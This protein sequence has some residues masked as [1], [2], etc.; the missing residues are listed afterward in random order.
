MRVFPNLAWPLTGVLAIVVAA[1]GM[2]ACRAQANLPLGLPPVPVPDAN[3][4]TPEKVALGEKLFFDRGLSADRTVSCGSCHLPG[5]FFSDSKALSQGIGG[6][7]GLR[8]APSLLN[9]AYARHLMWDG[10]STSL[11]DQMRYP[12]MNPL[13]MGNTPA[14]AVSYLAGN[15][16]YREPFRAAFGDETVVWQRV[17]RAIA[18]YERTLLSGNSDFD[19]YMA[20]DASALSLSAQRGFEIFRGAGGCAGCHVYSTES[21]FFTDFEFHNTG[22]V[23]SEP[24]DLGRYEISKEREDKGA[25]RTPSLRNVAK[26]GPY[27]HDGR[28]K[29][30]ADVVE[31]YGQ[32]DKPLRDGKAL[33]AQDKADLVA[34]LESL[35][36]QPGPAPQ[37]AS[38]QVSRNDQVR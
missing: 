27:M 35:T 10:R 21:P 18:S 8:N 29:A 25:F 38:D 15:P 34:F 19:R 17:E 14:G 36:S 24:A 28:M 23:W 37:P 26:T 32:G 20:G 30:L 6:R 22:L 4:M 11:E 3:P 13:E 7:F 9:A 16:D 12:L 31:F 33:S 5:H 2:A 1:M